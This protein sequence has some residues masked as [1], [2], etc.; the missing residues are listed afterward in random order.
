[1]K[2]ILRQFPIFFTLDNTARNYE[3]FF[4]WGSRAVCK[5]VKIYVTKNVFYKIRVLLYSG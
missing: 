5:F 2:R 1:M 4:F 3:L